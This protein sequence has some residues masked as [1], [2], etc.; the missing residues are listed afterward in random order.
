[1]GGY[2]K[3]SKKLLIVKY[4]C[5]AYYDYVCMCICIFKLFPRKMERFRANDGHINLFS[6]HKQH[7]RAFFCFEV[8]SLKDKRQIVKRYTVRRDSTDLY[9]LFSRAFVIKVSDGILSKYLLLYARIESKLG[10][11]M[12]GSK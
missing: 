5:L 11:R 7:L 6:K 12:N 9:K 3:A 2:K 10:K 8:I 1:M 4:R